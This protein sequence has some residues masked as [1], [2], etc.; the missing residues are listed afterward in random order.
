MQHPLS[1]SS[2]ILEGI[3]ELIGPLHHVEVGCFRRGEAPSASRVGGVR[4]S[5]VPGAAKCK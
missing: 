1:F 5:L 4:R 3:P 2:E